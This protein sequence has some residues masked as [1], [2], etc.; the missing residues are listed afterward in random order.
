MNMKVMAARNKTKLIQI[1]LAID[2]I[3]N[4]SLSYYFSAPDLYILF[5]RAKWHSSAILTE[6]YLC[7]FLSCKAN[8]RV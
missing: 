2:Y 5:S 6:V 3:Y 8:A 1:N 4:N 7:F